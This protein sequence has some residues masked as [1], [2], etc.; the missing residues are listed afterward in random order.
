MDALSLIKDNITYEQVLKVLDFKN[1]N[2]TD[3]DI[4]CS[5]GIHGGNNPTAFIVKKDN[6]LWYCHTGGCGGG[7][8]VKLVEKKLDLSFIEA[9]HWFAKTFD[10]DLSNLQ[11]KERTV[12]EQ[13]DLRKFISAIKSRRC[14]TFNKIEIPTGKRVLAFRNFSKEILIKHDVTFHERVTIINK[15]SEEVELRNRLLFPV[16]F[17]NVTV[18]FALRRTNNKDIPK[19]LNQPY[20]FD[21][22]DV[23]YNYDE[24]AHADEIVVVEGITDVIAFAEIGI[25]AVSTFGAHITKQQERLLLKCG[26]KITL[27]FD[28]DD[29]GRIATAKAIKSLKFKVDLSVI[30]F[31]EGQD[32]ENI[33]KEELIERFKRKRKYY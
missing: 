31:D 25:T 17:N 33:E 19:W 20:G 11:I 21:F 32:P 26:K 2:A 3:V 4:R 27:A 8:I 29:A 28:G 12:K 18:A 14:K 1:V 6:G 7:D 30:E 16:V 9:I 24:V 22:G 5:C 13:D 10:L 23:L 15:K